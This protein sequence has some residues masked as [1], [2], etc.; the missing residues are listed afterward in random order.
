MSRLLLILT[1]CLTA[2]GCANAPREKMMKMDL[3]TTVTRENGKTQVEALLRNAGTEPVRILL[4]FQLSQTYGSLTDD[5][6]RVLSAQDSRA[7]Q[8]R[9]NFDQP[10]KTVLLKPGDQV[11]VEGFTLLPEI[12]NA[13][14]R[15]MSWNLSEIRSKTLTLELSYQVTD[16]AAGLAKQLKAPD[17]AVGTWTSEPVTLPFKE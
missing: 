9:R 10:P 14:T 13:L 1:A 15:H 5:Q 2:E 7:A 6:G 11:R 17:V 4:E 12:P 8:G 16:E 3:V